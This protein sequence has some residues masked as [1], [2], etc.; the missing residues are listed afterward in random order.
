MCALPIACLFCS[1]ATRRGS[2]Y[3]MLPMMPPEPRQCQSTVN[4]TECLSSH[5]LGTFL[6]L[7]P[8]ARIS[9]DGR[10]LLHSNALASSDSGATPPNC[11]CITG[12]SPL[13]HCS[14]LA[15]APGLSDLSPI[16]PS[17]TEKRSKD[18]PLLDIESHSFFSRL[19]YLRH[20]AYVHGHLRREVAESRHIF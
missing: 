13:S 5:T 4:A 3:R 7:E 12:C 2:P 10:S 14:S 17:L 6:A 16:N 9:V 18:K 1:P 20:D 19:L 15:A 8:A 11:R